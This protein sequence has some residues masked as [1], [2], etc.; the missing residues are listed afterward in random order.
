M[1][2]PDLTAWCSTTRTEDPAHMVAPTVLASALTPV[3]CSSCSPKYQKRDL[4][5]F[6]TTHAC[7]VMGLREGTRNRGT[8]SRTAAHRGEFHRKKVKG[9]MVSGG[10]SG[11]L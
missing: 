4:L 6:S 3:P 8:A 9:T 7:P 11:E 1:Q 2:A 5:P 10:I